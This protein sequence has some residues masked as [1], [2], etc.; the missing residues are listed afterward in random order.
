MEQIG[1][2][3]HVSKAAIDQT[4]N[5]GIK[6]LQKNSRTRNLGEELGIWSRVILMDTEHVKRWV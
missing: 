2:Q 5:Q 4:L 6:M 3:L 1:E